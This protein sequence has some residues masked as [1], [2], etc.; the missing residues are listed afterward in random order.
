MAISRQRGEEMERKTFFSPTSSTTDLTK[1]N[2]QLN[3]RIY[4][5]KSVLL[6]AQ[7]VS[8]YSTKGIQGKK[9]KRT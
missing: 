5:E 8:T 3:A 9:K 4:S 6:A 7:A 2:P 1:S